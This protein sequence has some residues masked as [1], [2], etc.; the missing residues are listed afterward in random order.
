M[1]SKDKPGSYLSTLAV[2]NEAKHPQKHRRRQG[3]GCVAKEQR[4]SKGA[5]VRLHPV[6]YTVRSLHSLSDS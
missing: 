6:S 5:S 2:E 3:R 4:H 1:R